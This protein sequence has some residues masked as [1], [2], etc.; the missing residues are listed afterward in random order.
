[1]PRE[2][3][4][5][6]GVVREQVAPPVRRVTA[7]VKASL[8]PLA[9]PVPLAPRVLLALPAPL[10]PRVLL[11]LPAPLALRVLQARWASTRLRIRGR[12]T[13]KATFGR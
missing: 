6:P 4:S 11:A 5:T 12:Y 1:M 3:R 9:L 13:P 8:V 7:G 2:I 10:A